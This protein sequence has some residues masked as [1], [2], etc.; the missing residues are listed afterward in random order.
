MRTFII[1][2]AVSAV[3]LSQPSVN[4]DQEFNE[5]E[6]L[7][8]AEADGLF[9]AMVHHAKVVKRRR[10]RKAMIKA[11][12]RAVGLEQEDVEVPT[13]PEDELAEI[14][15]GEGNFWDKIKHAAKKGAS[16]AWH[17]R[18]EIEH[19]GK[20]AIHALPQEE[21]DVEVP[22]VPEDILSEI[23]EGEGSFWSKIKHA[24]SKGASFAWKHRSE[25]E[26]LAKEA[27]SHM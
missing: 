3:T 1:A 2:A 9:K 6:K 19:L 8:Q 23:A 4:F 22:T 11:G 21:E 27:A 16:F 26:H 18:S 7:V 20:E 5:G 24:A 14:A 15:E 12:L 10:E 25:I 17:H 13:V